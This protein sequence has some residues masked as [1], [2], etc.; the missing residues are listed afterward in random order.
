[1]KFMIILKKKDYF[2]LKNLKNQKMGCCCCKKDK[3]TGSNPIG[4]I[5]VESK[6]GDFIELKVIGKGAYGKVFLVQK[7]NTNNLYAMKRIKKSNIKSPKQKEHAI[8]EKDIQIKL[9]H[10]FI[11]ELYFA[12]QD[13]N[14][15]YLITEFMQGGQLFTYL[16]INPQLKNKQAKFYL[17]EIFLALK[18]MH[19]NN[20]IYRDLKPENILI[21]KD[22]HIKLSD[23]GFSK[24][25]NDEYTYTIC[26][27]PSYEAP[28]I[29]KKKG[30]D[31]MCDWWSF[32]I[33]MFEMLSGYKPFDIDKGNIN[34]D[35]YNNI[36]WC[37][38]IKDDAKDLIEKLLVIEPNMRLGYNDINDIGKHQ[39]FKDVDF[40]KVLNKEVEPPFVPDVKDE[41]DLKYFNSNFTEMELETF[42]ETKISGSPGQSNFEGFS[43]I[44]NSSKC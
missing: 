36:V 17:S 2:F 4:P 26:G 5:I 42:T 29:Y 20:Y 31:K 14:N 37:D 6:M 33:I 35:L 32:G 38:E 25:L 16:S 41:Y 27:T 22:G 44:Y 18:Y 13:Q 28:E 39:F 3:N 1:M 30:Y 9:K 34:D 23:F 24:L 15:L 12:F 21:G 8:N 10:P 43:Y 7:K 40:D 19:E 11:V